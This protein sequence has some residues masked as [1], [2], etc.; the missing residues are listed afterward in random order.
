MEAPVPAPRF[1]LETEMHGFMLSFMRTDAGEMIFW[2]QPPVLDANTTVKMDTT[3]V[4]ASPILVPLDDSTYKPHGQPDSNVMWISDWG[5]RAV[6]DAFG[7]ITVKRLIPRI[8]LNELQDVGIG[9]CTIELQTAAQEVTNVD[10]WVFARRCLQ[11]FRNTMTNFSCS[12]FEMDSDL[13]MISA[14]ADRWIP[15]AEFVAAYNSAVDAI[16]APDGFARDKFKFRISDRLQDLA[17]GTATGEIGPRWTPIVAIER[18]FDIVVKPPTPAYNQPWGHPVPANSPVLYCDVQLTYDMDLRSLFTDMADWQAMW[19]STWVYQFSDGV[20][21]VKLDSTNGLQRWKKVPTTDIYSTQLCKSLW[22]TAALA[23]DFHVN[24]IDLTHLP[25]GGTGRPLLKALV[26]YLFVAGASTYPEGNTS[27]A[28]N[29]FPQLPKT[30]PA[31]IA[32]ALSVMFPNFAPQLQSLSTLNEVERAVL[33]WSQIADMV[34]QPPQLASDGPCQ[35]AMR[36]YA[37]REGGPLVKPIGNMNAYF[38]NMW[39]GTFNL[40]GIAAAYP[41]NNGFSS[42]APF[43]IPWAKDTQSS[44]PAARTPGVDGMDLKILIESRYSSCKLNQGFNAYATDAM[45]KQSYLSLV[46]FLAPAALANATNAVNAYLPGAGPALAQ[47]FPPRA[48]GGQYVH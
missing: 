31:S 47:V 45:F 32:R 12:T 15:L 11:A 14:K 29:S 39:T 35:G 7:G 24:S 44:R 16:Q 10:Y 19:A 26:T 1:G 2:K 20:V 40:T 4:G 23:A 5:F 42:L 21:D 36:T 38:R 25:A 30:S 22:T 13:L 46:R 37:N 3:M 9:K 27:T 28:K 6:G 18:G 34:L 48:L 41:A 8:S 43:H 17:A 33:A